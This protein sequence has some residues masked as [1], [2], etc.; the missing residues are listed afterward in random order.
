ML[1][2]IEKDDA[3]EL[4]ALVD[5]NRTYL[6]EWLPWL[7]MTNEVKDVEVF[8][9]RSLKQ[10][11]EGVGQ[12]HLIIEGNEIRGVCG[13]NKIDKTNRSAFIGYWLSADAQGRGLMTKACRELERIAFEELDMNKVEIHAA[14]GNKPSRAVAERLGYQ[15]T[16][17]SLDA[18][19]LY[20]HFVSFVLYCKRQSD[21]R[22]L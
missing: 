3:D 20:D 2:L 15:E 11:E 22:T 19:W 7:D 6:R 10:H 13:F 14:E 16:G 21:W 1:K 18:E 8:I 12:A 4:F 5:R 17:R 9:E